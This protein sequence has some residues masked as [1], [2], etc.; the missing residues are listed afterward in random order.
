[1]IFTQGIDL[2]AGE[3]VEVASAKRDPLDF[4]LWKSSRESEPSE[5]KW[6][7]PWGSGRPGWHI[8]CSAMSCELLGE[9][10][11][12]HG[13]GQDLQFPHHEN[14]IAQSEGAS[15]KRFVNYWMH[16]GFVRVDDEKMS[17]SL[18]N[19]F[20]IREVLDSRDESGAL[21]V[22]HPEVLRYLNFV[23]DRLDLKRDIRFNTRVKSARW[24]EAAPA[25]AAAPSALLW[26]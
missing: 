22:R 2:R 7:S 3:R 21:R 5:V 24:D 6:A 13:G 4:V 14:E 26:R 12:I 23:A 19:F 20:T 18:G 10:F 1:M 15:G 8:E 25:L 16:N 9:Q 11:D 17:K